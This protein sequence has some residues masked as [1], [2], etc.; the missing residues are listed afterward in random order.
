MGLAI[1]NL[2]FRGLKLVGWPLKRFLEMYYLC[3][4]WLGV[5]FG[6]GGGPNLPP[7]QIRHK[8]GLSFPDS[9]PATLK[10]RPA[11]AKSSSLEPDGS[12]TYS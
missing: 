12:Y 2:F 4:M 8:C 5:H 7:R 3:R 11:T 9:L 10:S 1:G 6:L